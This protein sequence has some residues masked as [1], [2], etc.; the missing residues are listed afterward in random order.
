VGEIDVDGKL[1]LKLI[2][3]IEYL[4]GCLDLSGSG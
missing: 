1:I 3:K 2:L 4:W